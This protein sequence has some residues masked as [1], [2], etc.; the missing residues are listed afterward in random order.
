MAV[1]RYAEIFAAHRWSVP[2]QF[3]IA[4]A[5]CTRWANE[6]PALRCTG[7]TSRERRL[8]YTFWDL[9]QQA[10]R[11]SN[12]LAALGV[13]PRRQDRAHPPAAAGDRRRASRRLSARRRRRPAVVPVRSRGAVLPVDRF[14]REDRFRRSAVARQSRAGARPMSR[15]RARRG[16]RRRDRSMGHALRIVAAAGIAPLCAGGDARGRSGASHLHERH[17]RTAEG[18]A[19]AA[20]VPHRQPVRIRPLARR[21][22]PRRRSLLV[23]GRLGMDRRPDG[24][25]PS[26]ALFRPADRRLSRALRSGARA[27]ADREVRHPQC[28]PVSDRTQADDEGVS[29]PERAVRSSAAHDHERGRSC[30]DLASSTGRATRLASRSTRCS[31]KPR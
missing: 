7:R 19:D 27:V 31:D 22:S 16:C 8:R 24:R 25:A 17:D 20:A 9:Q 5:C 4:Q 12:A 6:R 15:P 18:R 11:L 1:D 29:A 30:R 10:N 13:R 23:A 26:D 28:V 3:N 2:A 14:R 21:L